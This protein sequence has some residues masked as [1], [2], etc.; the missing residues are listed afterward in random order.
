M[1]IGGTG[2]YPRKQ[3]A[4]HPSLLGKRG[5]R[6]RKGERIIPGEDGKLKKNPGVAKIKRKENGIKKNP[7]NRFK[8]FI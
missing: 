2:I 3:R 8:R 7:R 5:R 4:G 6:Q 1:C